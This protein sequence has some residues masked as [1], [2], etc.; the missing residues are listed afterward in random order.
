MNSGRARGVCTILLPTLDFVNKSIQK[1]L[2]KIPVVR[3]RSQSREKGIPLLQSKEHRAGKIGQRKKVIA[4]N[5][6]LMT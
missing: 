2:I 1:K 4:S 5:I 3:K 6:R